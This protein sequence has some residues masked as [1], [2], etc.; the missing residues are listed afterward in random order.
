MGRGT[1]GLSSD[2]ILGLDDQEVGELWWEATS[3]NGESS[4]VSAGGLSGVSEILQERGDSGSRLI[5]QGD[6][7]CRRRIA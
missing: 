2:D 4:D 3:K 1:G 6:R 5:N 7:D